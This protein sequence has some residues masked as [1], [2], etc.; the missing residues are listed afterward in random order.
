MV[1]EVRRLTVTFCKINHLVH[2]NFDFRILRE[3]RG[4]IIDLNVALR[5]INEAEVVSTIL[6]FGALPAVSPCNPS[7]LILEQKFAA[8]GL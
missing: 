6:R 3:L 4:L 7:E 5:L 2:I 1:F 8:L